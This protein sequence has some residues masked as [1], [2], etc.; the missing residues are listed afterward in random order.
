MIRSHARLRSIFRS[1]GKPANLA[2]GIVRPHQNGL[3]HG[4]PP[5]F[6]ILNHDAIDSGI[7]GESATQRVGI[8]GIPIRAGPRRE[9]GHLFAYAV[10]LASLYDC[11]KK[12]YSLYSRRRAGRVYPHEIDIQETHPKHRKLDSQVAL[13]HPMRDRP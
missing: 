3:A 5:Q 7:P 9:R 8:R 1:L 10:T 11:A 4:K 13:P 2:G 6:A 12:A